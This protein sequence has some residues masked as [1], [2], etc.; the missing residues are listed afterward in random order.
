[1]KILVT[2]GAGYIGSHTAKALARAGH[3]PV[4]FDNLSFGH[5]WAVRWGPLVEGDLSDKA[6]LRSVL[7]TH[8]I[9][10]VIHFAASAYVGESMQNP[11]KY[12]RNNVVNTLNLLDAMMDAKVKKI[13]FSSTCATYGDPQELPITERHPQKP[14]NPYGDSKLFV[15]QM[16]KWYG[17]AYGLHW[18]ALRYFNAAGAD[19]D[20]A[21]GENHTPETHLIP[22]AIQAA[23]GLRPYLEV[24]GTE[25]PTPDGSA[26]R[27]Y[28]HVNDL[29]DAHIR[30][31]GHLLDGGDNLA[32]NLGTG[33]GYSVREVIATVE[34]VS[35]KSVP[36]R[37]TLPRAGDPAELIADASEAR[38]VLGWRPVFNDLE[39][40]VRSAW[41]WHSRGGV[42]RELQPDAEDTRQTSNA[43]D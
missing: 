27:D 12:F 2:G 16:L 19:P 37:L 17:H 8:E 42:A 24:F 4:V 10:A 38:R 6:L 13:V 29:A 41:N 23:M 36:V 43:A 30:A 15:E 28:V 26:V 25:Y 11:R 7:E 31:L 20:G 33:N 34:R 40:I 3:Q 21:I 32:L 5:R 18:T 14:V 39:S 9:D 35:Q 22:L 1:M